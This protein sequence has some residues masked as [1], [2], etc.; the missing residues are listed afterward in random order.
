[1]KVWAHNLAIFFIIEWLYQARNVI[2]HLY[3]RYMD[4]ELASV[5]TIFAIAFWSCS[6]SV[7]LISYLFSTIVL[8]IFPEH[9][10][11]ECDP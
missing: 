3:V 7:I 6:D 10:E 9:V 2:C 5:L 1:M 8:N 4:I 11:F